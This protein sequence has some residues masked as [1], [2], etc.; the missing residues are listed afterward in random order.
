MKIICV[1][2]G[3]SLAIAADQLGTKGRCPHC[4]QEISLPKAESSKAASSAA[5]PRS[6]IANW[7]DG[8]LSGMAS[9]V[10]HLSLLLAIAIFSS[11]QGSGEG[12]TNDVLIGILPSEQLSDTVEEQ[13]TTDEVQ[14]DQSSDVLSESLQVESPSNAAAGDGLLSLSDLSPSATDGGS[15]DLGTVQLGGGSMAG[16]SWDGMLQNLRR[17]GLDIVLC[18][19][20]T[21]SMSGEI[22]QVKRQIERIGTTLVTLVP[23]ARISVC[24][25]RDEGD[26]YVVKGS[27]LTGSIQ[28]VSQYLS[29]ITAGGGGDL[30]EAV[31]EGLYHATTQNRFRPQARKVI[32]IFGDAPPHADKLAR[33]V[34]LAT[35]FR[36]Q[37]NGVVSTVT[38]RAI[39]PLP[40]FYE[41]AASGGGEAFLTTDQKQ[42]VS[43]LMVLVFGSRHR[44][45]VL[46]AFKLLDAAGE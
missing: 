46:E 24:T 7:I 41:I 29:G 15:M 5:R 2:C 33:C 8:S 36:K 27:P 10:I 19:D 44:S 17:N 14:K 13:I 31:E 16:G 38:C 6:L 11:T 21:G 32:L 12:T 4:K 28:E 18:F 22:D 20:S 40:E 3:G 23:K 1:H 42:I 35:G 37:Q 9:L 45:K 25:Y 43:Q 26:E 34:E 30:P 39:E